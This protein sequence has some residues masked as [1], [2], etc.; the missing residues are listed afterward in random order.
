MGLVINLKVGVDRHYEQFIYLSSSNTNTDGQAV[1]EILGDKGVMQEDKTID[2]QRIEV[3]EIVWFPDNSKY[4]RVLE[5][6]NKN[7][8][9]MQSLHI[10]STL[11]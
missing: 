1:V 8:E 5:L 10:V 4:C 11:A 3:G 6:Y 9:P 2:P 7:G